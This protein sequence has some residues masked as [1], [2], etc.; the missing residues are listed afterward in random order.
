MWSP[1]NYQ[2][3]QKNLFNSFYRHGNNDHCNVRFSTFRYMWLAVIIKHNIVLSN[4]TC[5]VMLTTRRTILEFSNYYRVNL[6]IVS[7]KQTVCPTKLLDMCVYGKLL[8]TAKQPFGHFY[9]KQ[10][11]HKL[12]FC[13]L[14]FLWLYDK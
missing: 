6:Y 10:R 9:N 3:P 8:S 11:K 4:Y 7:A 1:W 5:I 14:Y 13:K 2:L 12:Y